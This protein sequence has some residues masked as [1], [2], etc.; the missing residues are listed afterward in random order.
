MSDPNE[1]VDTVVFTGAPQA[2][3]YS[4]TTELER[5]TVD[6]KDWRKVRIQVRRYQRNYQCDRYGSFN[7]GCPV[8]DDPRT[9]PLGTGRPAPSNYARR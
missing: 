8:L 4:Y 3:D 5:F 2:A 9:H 7:G 6:G 1:L